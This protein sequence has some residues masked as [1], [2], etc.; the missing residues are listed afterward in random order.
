VAVHRRHHAHADQP[1][2]PH[3]PVVFGLR[4]VLLEGYELYGVAAHDPK[5]LSTYGRGTP[6]DWL[7]RR[8]YAAHPYAGIT[9]FVL[10]HLL[11]FGGRA[12]S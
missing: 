9:V 7:E 11:L 3:S 2:D 10:L 8:V 6:D 1:G 5:T 12:S 4:R